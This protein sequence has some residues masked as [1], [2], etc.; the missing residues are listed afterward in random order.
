MANSILNCAL[1]WVILTNFCFGT[2]YF[3]TNR[4]DGGMC[5]QLVID[6]PGFEYWGEDAV[7]TSP[8]AIALA[9]GRGSGDLSSKY[10]SQA[11]VDNSL[12]FRLAFFGA[13]KRAELANDALT[14]AH[15]DHLFVSLKTVLT[16]LHTFFEAG[17]K[18]N[19]AAKL[20]D[21][22]FN[23]GSHYFTAWFVTEANK[24]HLIIN[25]SGDIQA[26]IF[27]LV[28]HSPE[29]GKT[30]FY[31]APKFMTSSKVDKKAVG[32]A[33]KNITKSTDI[34]SDN[35]KLDPVESDLLVVGSNGFF[36]NMP[37]G[38]M[39]MLINSFMYEFKV[40]KELLMERLLPYLKVYIK[41]M[42]ARYWVLEEKYKNKKDISIEN[43][44]EFDS[45]PAADAK[46]KVDKKGQLIAQLMAPLKQAS[47]DKYKDLIE[48]TKKEEDKAKLN[49]E[50][51]KLEEERS[52]WE[53]FFRCPMVKQT[54]KPE[55]L[56]KETDLLSD[57]VK[58]IISSKLSALE[59]DKNSFLDLSRQVLR[60]GLLAEF[61]SILSRVSAKMASPVAIEN[62]VR[63]TK[64][65]KASGEP[66]DITVVASAIR[67]LDAP[68]DDE[69]AG[70]KKLF[71]AQTGLWKARAKRNVD[72]IIAWRVKNK[73]RAMIA[74]V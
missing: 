57:C 9:G 11:I 36:K 38:L 30:L 65:A 40:S 14:A 44:N 5:Y 62:W 54:M 26:V 70:Y 25:K 6:K 1:S 7:A 42:E 52:A 33:L 50:K 53:A 27:K 64:D 16:D 48:K 12:L 29:A 2:L 60:A 39:T 66:D 69:I 74:L 19:P 10:L 8:V 68:T 13:G 28:Q 71:S 63:G 24:Q 55:T 31:Y 22:N 51:A 34:E 43:E 45:A 61:A 59:A 4:P 47:D 58:N 32:E 18:A 3:D 17:K 21:P 37:L 23:V 35:Y 56:D 15:K 46:G 20:P 67:T 72:E 41:V 73:R 49:K